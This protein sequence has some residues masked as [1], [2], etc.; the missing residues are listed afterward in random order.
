L[1]PETRFAVAKVTAQ[2]II[3]L[4]FKKEPFK[5]VND[6]DFTTFINDVI[7]DQALLLEGRVGSTTYALTTSPQKDYV[8]RAEKALCAAEMIARRINIILSN[9]TGAGQE[10]DTS[11]EEKQRKTYLDEAENWVTSSVTYSDSPGDCSFGAAISS[12][13]GDQYA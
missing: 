13:F 12:H 2:D 5:I 8:K 10:L 7:A 3:N 6:G 1:R 11:S 9:V 4:G